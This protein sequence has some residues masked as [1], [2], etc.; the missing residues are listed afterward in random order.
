MA[1]TDTAV[2]QA[3]PADKPHKLA[4]EKE[5]Y[6]LINQ[7][8]KSWRMNY[9]YQGKQKTLAF[10]VYPDTTLAMA[11]EKRDIARQILA[12]GINPA[13]QKKKDKN[14]VKQNT[15]NSFFKIAQEWHKKESPRWT[16]DHAAC[17]MR[18]LEFDAFPTLGAMPIAS[19]TAPD[20][21]KATG[22]KAYR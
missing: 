21:L 20:I 1:L 13:E 4:D 12:D 19:I 22:G 8:G 2:R 10:G 18:P 5:L 16:P 6:L 9:R 11:R 14:T 7:T 3:K 15:I 17:I